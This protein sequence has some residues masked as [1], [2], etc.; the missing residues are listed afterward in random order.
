MLVNYVVFRSCRLLLHMI[1]AAYL[2]DAK[3]SLHECYCHKN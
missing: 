3:I 1:K 2:L